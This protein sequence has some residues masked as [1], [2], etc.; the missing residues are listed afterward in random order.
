MIRLWDDLNDRYAPPEVV[1][2]LARIAL[3]SLEAEPAAWKWR[4]TSLYDDAQVGPWRLCLAPLSP[5]AG[6][7]CKTE[8]I[9]LYTAPTM[10]QGKS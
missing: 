10:F 4:L 8:A 1:R 6:A 9:A 2:E 7:G 5:G 3:V